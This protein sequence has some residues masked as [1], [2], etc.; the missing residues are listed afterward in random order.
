M[1]FS[2]LKKKLM[3]MDDDAIEEYLGNMQDKGKYEKLTLDGP[4]AKLFDFDP[5]DGTISWECPEHDYC[6]ADLMD[7]FFDNARMLKAFE[8]HGCGFEE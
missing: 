4:Y 8:K 6:E 7:L 1:K 5:E 3:G 2:E